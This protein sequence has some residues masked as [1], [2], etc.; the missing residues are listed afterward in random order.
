MAGTEAKLMRQRHVVSVVAST[1][2]LLTAGTGEAIGQRSKL[3]EFGPDAIEVPRPAR[4][5][6][7]PSLVRTVEPVA[8]RG[9]PWVLASA[10][11]LRLPPPPD[12]R[13][14]ARERLELRKLAAGDDAEALERIRHWDAGPPE[15]R[16]KEMLADLSVRADFADGAV[17]RAY[18]LLDIAIH[19]AVI[20]AWDSKLA[21]KRPRP[22]ELD[23]RLVPE[24]AVPRSP[25]YPCEIAV[26]AGA[27]A[28]IL[29]HLF[30]GD[31]DRL[32]A[33]AHEAAW[34]G[35]AASVAYPSDAEAGLALGRAVAARVI[36]AARN[37]SR[38]I[39]ALAVRRA[40]LPAE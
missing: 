40:G 25:S 22:S 27:A 12:E 20:A 36:D 29:A 5:A 8:A 24:A 3:L 7:D 4:V 18:E 33:A 17:S 14:T 38:W 13:E 28:A 26:T 21:Y 32:I 19:D 31:A 30:P 23:A 35:V 10:W 39:L 34:S 6:D 1:A 37:D 15:R 9:R 16:W 2:L 11:E